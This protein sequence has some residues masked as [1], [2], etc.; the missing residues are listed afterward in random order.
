MPGGSS[1]NRLS[2]RINASKL[3]G[4]APGAT[5]SSPHPRNPSVRSLEQA[6]KLAGK[7]R[8]GFPEAK[9]T[10]SRRS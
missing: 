8:I 7:W 5:L 2:V 9:R 10:R 6:P 4:M 3:S 1:V